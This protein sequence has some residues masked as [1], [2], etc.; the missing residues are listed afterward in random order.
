MHQEANVPAVSES[1]IARKDKSNLT[2]WQD[3]R[4]QAKW[5]WGNP[6]WYLLLVLFIYGPAIS[7]Y[8]WNPLAWYWPWIVYG[9]VGPPLWL[10]YAVF[11]NRVRNGVWYGFARFI[12]HRGFSCRCIYLPWIG[13]SINS[14]LG[15]W[16]NSGSCWL[17]DWNCDKWLMGAS[18]AEDKDH[19]SGPIAQRQSSRFI[20]CIS[21]W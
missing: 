21:P 2:F 8:G 7:R 4:F 17:C 1:P 3:V 16:R 11:F 5:C 12:G 15:D 14:V 9:I 13:V 10:I 6:A 19:F 18:A 20:P